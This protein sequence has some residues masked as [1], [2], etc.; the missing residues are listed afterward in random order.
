M[1]I[2][3][4]YVYNGRNVHIK[5]SPT[6][7]AY[8]DTYNNTSNVGYNFALETIEGTTLKRKLTSDAI[9]WNPK[10]RDVAH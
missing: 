7:Y 10:K 8:M 6:S 4:P 2:K 1:Y 9:A 5:L 3:N